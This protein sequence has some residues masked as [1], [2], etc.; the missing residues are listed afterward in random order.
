[1]HIDHHHRGELLEH[2]PRA[3]SG[4][5]IAQPPLQGHLQAVG[6]EGDEDVRFNAILALVVDGPEGQVAFEIF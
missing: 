5:Q 6:Q 4:R 2:G 1:M 3:Q